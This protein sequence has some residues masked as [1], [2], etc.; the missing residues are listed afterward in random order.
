MFDHNSL[1]F[2]YYRPPE[3]FLRVNP[4]KACIHTVLK[5]V[6]RLSV[7]DTQCSHFLHTMSTLSIIEIM[8]YQY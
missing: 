3:V 1:I 6:H 8:G 4:G 2:S 5:P 7:H